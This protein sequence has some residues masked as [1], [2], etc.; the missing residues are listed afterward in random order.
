MRLQQ[1]NNGVWE[2]E[3]ALINADTKEI[4][5]K[6]DDCHDKI[7]EYIN[8]FLFG[9][10]YLNTDF[11]LLDNLNVL[12][13][14]E[15]FEFCGFYDDTLDYRNEDDDEENL[16]SNEDK[17]EEVH[18]NNPIIIK[19]EKELP[20]SER[21]D[22]KIYGDVVKILCTNI[23]DAL[24]LTREHEGDLWRV[25]F[26]VEEENIVYSCLGLEKEDNNDLLKPY[27][28]YIDDDNNIKICE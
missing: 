18:Y 8:G 17:E 13:D 16:I 10:Q 27:G 5:V 11:E 26:D 4:I 20:H 1:I 15:L 24:E 12:P 3:S 25:D 19:D 28:I 23:I 22:F 14:N 7:N 2:E 21:H 9:L 6:G